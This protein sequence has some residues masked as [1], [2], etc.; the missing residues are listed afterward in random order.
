MGAA[1]GGGAQKTVVVHALYPTFQNVDEMDQASGLVVLGTPIETFDASAHVG[2]ASETYEGGFYTFRK[3]KV[4]KVIKSVLGAAVKPGDVVSIVE[5]ATV[6][7]YPDG[8][9]VRLTTDDYVPMN[10]GQEYIIFTRPGTPGNY[11]VL[12]HNLGKL[13]YKS[14]LVSGTSPAVNTQFNKEQQDKFSKFIDDAKK[15]YKL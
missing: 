7:T 5:P 4:R 14:V 12:N 9:K 3:V 13:P 8:A 6:L 15:K 11:V 2:E 10:K 1:L